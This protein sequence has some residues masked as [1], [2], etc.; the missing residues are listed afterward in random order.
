MRIDPALPTKQLQQKSAMTAF[1]L[2]FFFGFLG[3]HRFY[4]RKRGTGL[5]MLLTLGGF[6]IWTFVD[7]LFIVN[8]KME[9]GDGNT[10]RFLKNPTSVKTALAVISTIVAWCALSVIT[11]LTTVFYI[12][13][14]LV[15][16]VQLQLNALKSGDI[17]TAY[18]L[19]SKDFQQAT[20]LNDFTVFLKSYPILKEN[21]NHSFSFR[22]VE[23]NKG[24]LIGTLTAKDGSQTAVTYLLIKE[25]G[26]WKILGISLTPNDAGIKIKKTISEKSM[27]LTNTYLAKNHGYVISYPANWTVTH[28]KKNIVLFSGKIG[29]ASYYS[30]INIQ[31]ILSK[32]SGGHYESTEQLLLILKKQMKNQLKNI[33]IIEEGKATLPQNP[34]HFQGEYI[35]F[36]YTLKNQPFKQLQYLFSSENKSVFYSWAYTSAAQQYDSDLTIAKTMFASWKIIS[37]QHH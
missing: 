17:K 31:T 15:N 9:D 2:C 27:L 26:T 37:K 34:N 16:V 30:T 18:A 1:L 35:I 25:N 7:L 20:S 10:I 29:T 36:S 12:T 19:N 4:L 8:N 6:G 22:E 23:N 5:L 32:K 21:K 14:D 11:L 28:P 24:I 33:H 13:S 3:L